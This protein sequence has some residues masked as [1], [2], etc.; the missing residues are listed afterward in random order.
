MCL[1]ISFILCRFLL[2]STTQLTLRLTDETSPRSEYT[3]DTTMRMQIS[4]SPYCFW[5]C[6]WPSPPPLHLFASPPPPS[7]CTL[8]RWPRWLAGGTQELMAVQHQHS[9]RLRWLWCLMKSATSIILARL[10]SKTD[11]VIHFNLILTMYL[12]RFH[13]CAGDINSGK[14]S[15]QGDSGGPLMIS[16]NGR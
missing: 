5:P 3:Q 15:C 14:D 16:E 2:G 10:K 7:P 8:A 13:I 11:N 1:F 12:C 9:R 4:I 6:P